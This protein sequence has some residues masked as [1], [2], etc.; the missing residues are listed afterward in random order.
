MA[1]TD[2]RQVIDLS[3]KWEYTCDFGEAPGDPSKARWHEVAVPSN[4]H[5]AGLPDHHGT[6]WY[7]HNFSLPEIDKDQRSHLRFHG[8]DYFADVWL[9]DT[10]VG[11][12]EGYFQTFT[13]GITDIVRREN[14]L[15][16]KVN[17]PKEGPEAWPKHKRLIKGIL[18]MHDCRPGGWNPERGQDGNT[19]G[20]WNKVDVWISNE[21]HIDEIRV[22][23]VVLSTTAARLQVKADIFSQYTREVQGVLRISHVENSSRIVVVE[24]KRRIRL[25]PGS[26]TQT[27][28][29]TIESP[30]LWWTW[31]RG[32]Q[33]FYVV[34]LEL[35]DNGLILDELEERCGIRDFQIDPDGI[36]YL[37][38][39]RIFPRGTN[40]LPA[41]WLSEYTP[42]RIAR[43]VRLL[44][45]A[46]VNA[47][48]LHAHVNRKELYDALDEAGIMVWQDFPLQWS[49]AD[50]DQFAEN[51]ATQIQEMVRGLYNH[52]SIVIWACHNEP[53][54]NRWTLDPILANAVKQ[55]DAS[56]VVWEA[57]ATGEHPYPGWYYGSYLEFRET[58]ARPL[59]TEFGAQALPSVK[60]LR[61]MFSADKLFPPDGAEWAYRNF[62]SHE[63][64]NVAGVKMGGNIETFVENSQAYQSRLLQF[65][66]ENYRRKKYQGVTGL[67][68]FMFVDCW[69][70]ITWS[71][72]DYDR[73]PKQGY[74]AL[75]RAYQPV[76]GSL[77][78]RQDL[79]S[80]GQD[81]N[82][83][84]T[85]I[86]DLMEH[87]SSVS[88]TLRVLDPTGQLLEHWHGMT[89][90]PPD[91]TVVLGDPEAPLHTWKVPVEAVAGIYSIEI[92]LLS[93]T[94]EMLST[95]ATTFTV[96]SDRSWPPVY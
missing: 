56:R 66:I 41:Q 15:L 18:N 86:N 25:N 37:N 12:H 21:T 20:I 60:L 64:F 65:A 34:E 16:V 89:N 75:K 91:S 48:R 28:I 30:Q 32:P 94:K 62:Q 90:V 76:L 14:T 81:V 33:N 70:S 22:T 47:V 13:F 23:S 43:D 31:D 95:N 45:E 26:N 78:I 80:M 73:V 92:E 1:K 42:E 84:L 29:Q 93:A 50:D 5:L 3:G 79:V 55:I 46:N 8:L 82:I 7:R 40:L 10:Y 6:V 83:G 63:T 71:V 2:S 36:W 4:W 11:H 52:P 58:P 24:E 61:E 68:Q 9:N 67:F 72:V 54:E 44:V 19:G 51:A 96:F 57:S 49:Y 85:I 74:H 39:Q 87:L 27:F 59:V 38:G 17:S 77:Q 53:A 35:L 69:P 88:W